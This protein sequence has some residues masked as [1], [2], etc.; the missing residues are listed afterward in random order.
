MDEASGSSGGEAALRTQNAESFGN[1]W[2]LTVRFGPQ[3]CRPPVHSK[4]MEPKQ[5]EFRQPGGRA[6]LM[7]PD[8]GD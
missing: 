4:Q 2:S 7:D 1:S 3:H 6:N 5:T 8:W